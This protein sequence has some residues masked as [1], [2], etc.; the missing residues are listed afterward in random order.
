M[1]RLLP[2]ACFLPALLMGLVALGLTG[3]YAVNVTP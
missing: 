3:G 1:K 2:L